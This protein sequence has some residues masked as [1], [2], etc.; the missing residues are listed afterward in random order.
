MWLVKRGNGEKG[1]ERDIAYVLADALV[2]GAARVAAA[3]AVCVVAFSARNTRVG[4]R[5]R[6][7]SSGAGADARA[8]R[9]GGGC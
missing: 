4:A 2:D 9:R 8:S 6:A 3:F 1:G 7:R 5:A